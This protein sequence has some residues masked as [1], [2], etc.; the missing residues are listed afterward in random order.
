MVERVW[1]QN[2]E[3]HYILGNV[4]AQGS[5][6]KRTRR[7]KRKYSTIYNRTQNFIGERDFNQK[8]NTY[9]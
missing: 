5:G 1:S 9:V 2:G 8:L 3:R 7:R 6:G 4:H